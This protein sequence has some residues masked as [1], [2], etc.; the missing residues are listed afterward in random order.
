MQP[1]A[2]PHPNSNSPSLYQPL[3][4][5]QA[6]RGN[7]STW[8]TPASLFP[9]ARLAPA[10]A[11]TRSYYSERTLGLG[12]LTPNPK[13]QAL[14]T[15]EQLRFGIVG[16]TG[17]NRS[18]EL[19]NGFVNLY[20][21]Q[22]SSHRRVGSGLV[23]L[24][25]S[26]P[27]GLRF[28]A[29]PEP[30][31]STV[32]R[33]SF[34]SEP[35]SRRPSWYSNKKNTYDWAEL[36]PQEIKKV[37]VFR[38][39]YV[40]RTKEDEN[41]ADGYLLFGADGK[42]IGE[43]PY[44]AKN[45][46]QLFGSTHFAQAQK[47][48]QPATSLTDANPKPRQPVNQ[49]TSPAWPLPAATEATATIRA[50]DSPAVGQ[51]VGSGSPVFGVSSNGRPV[52]GFDES[53][54]PLVGWNS[55][56][57]AV[58]DVT[59]E[60][61]HVLDFDDA[62]HSLLGYSGQ[63][64]PVFGLS[65]AGYVATELDDQ[66]RPVFAFDAS[67]QP[68]SS[69]DLRLIEQLASTATPIAKDSYGN[70]VF[71]YD[72]NGYPI[73]T[74]SKEGRPVIGFDHRNNP[75][76]AVDRDHGFVYAIDQ[77]GKP[78]FGYD[79]AGNTIYKESLADGSKQ[80]DRYF[81]KGRKLQDKSLNL[82]HDGL[83]RL[84]KAQK[85]DRCAPDNEGRKFIV[86]DRNGNK[87][88]NPDSLQDSN[89]RPIVS[90]RVV[91]QIGREVSQQALEKLQ[92][93]TKK[94]LT[95]RWREKEVQVAA[96]IQGAAEERPQQADGREVTQSRDQTA[97]PKSKPQISEPKATEF[98]NPELKAPWL[99][100]PDQTDPAVKPHGVSVEEIKVPEVKA[101]NPKGNQ[102]PVPEVEVPEPKLEKGHNAQQQEN[103]STLTVQD[104]TAKADVKDTLPDAGR[105]E[106]NRPGQPSTSSTAKL[107]ENQGETLP[108]EQAKQE[109]FAAH[110]PQEQTSLPANGNRTPFLLDGLYLLP[111]GLVVDAASQPCGFVSS[112]VFFDL[113]SKPLACISASSKLL[114]SQGNTILADGSII[115]STGIKLGHFKLPHARE[116]VVPMS[117]SL[118]VIADPAGHK[119]IGFDKSNK[120][121]I[122]SNAAGD[123][124]YAKQGRDSQGRLVSAI[125]LEG[126]AIPDKDLHEMVELSRQDHFRDKAHIQLQK[127]KNSLEL[128]DLTAANFV[129]ELD[130]L[131]SKSD[132][133]VSSHKMQT[134]PVLE[135][136][137]EEDEDSQELSRL[138]VPKRKASDEESEDEHKRA[139]S[140]L[141]SIRQFLN[142]DTEAANNQK[143]GKQ[144]PQ[145]PDLAKT[146]IAKTDREDTE[147]KQD[148]ENPQTKQHQ[149]SKDKNPSEQADQTLDPPL[150]TEEDDAKSDSLKQ[151]SE[152]EDED[153][154]EDEEALT[155][156]RRLREMKEQRD[157]TPSPET[158]QLAEAALSSLENTQTTVLHS[159]EQLD[160]QKALYQAT[161][162]ST[163]S[164]TC[165]SPS[166]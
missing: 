82:L 128:K 72:S 97:N 158:K 18:V 48:A 64:S 24:P 22:S 13:P 62:G 133:A 106:V 5:L 131:T 85:F 52:L 104:N 111:T 71:G 162:E 137:E 138:K 119:I 26:P 67:G 163:P 153:E 95:D 32:R 79:G 126:D 127:I 159:I 8:Q 91:D 122:G 103:Q 164:S 68:H 125:N 114:D 121:V 38:G 115:A 3:A 33:G 145:K 152:E 23:S 156:I 118:P 113:D 136:K 20:D 77:Q 25:Q 9:E 28:E 100:A 53:G 16:D 63:K 105:Q 142:L 75:V 155:M 58:Y 120:L 89:H 140:D 61:W 56:G 151:P 149:D 66:Q 124:I 65:Q 57:T 2:H 55:A 129:Q 130:H 108:T 59:K 14:R 139:K 37:Q 84:V 78:V 51:L 116:K 135:Q 161:V 11:E 19:G 144:E 21:P 123:P 166:R 40:V 80:I 160:Q 157:R 31:R 60:G 15:S 147:S 47:E 10:Q 36:D 154:D 99:Q 39:Y 29:S 94:H 1:A 41:D 45:L 43:K 81:P 7:S 4:R 27:N 83:G 98:D 42:R 54:L 87:V 49:A 69:E 30:E 141:G 17:A 134:V 6:T 44:T 110:V 12:V 35:R 76:L 90:D 93:E 143:T 96:K 70:P 107:P 50:K 102:L 92:Q 34:L 165:F 148:Q 150:P 132:R 74:V 109:D 86:E 112:G 88:R 101:S 73:L 146:D 117:E 46:D